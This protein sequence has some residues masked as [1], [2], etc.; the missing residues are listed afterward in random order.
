M[1]PDKLDCQA[2]VSD[3]AGPV[4]F[5]QD[6]FALQVSVSDGRF[7][8]GTEDLGVEVTETRHRGVGQPQHGFVVQRGGFEVV[9]QGA[10]F[11]VVGDQVELGPGAG[12]FNVSGYETCVSGG[13]A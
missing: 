10:V 7:A 5:H 9:V 8:L 12:A 3:A 1:S 4:S 13:G 2:Q 11:V 6:V